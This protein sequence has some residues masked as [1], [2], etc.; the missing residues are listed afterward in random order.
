M[1]IP[2]TRVN[3]CGM[4]IKA[5]FTDPD[6]ARLI[7]LRNVLLSRPARVVPVAEPEAEPNPASE[8]ARPARPTFEEIMAVVN[9]PRRRR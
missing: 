5:E 2:N 7:K 3:W 4:T 9:R 6:S 1:A 8:A